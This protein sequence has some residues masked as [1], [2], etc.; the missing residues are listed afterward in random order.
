MSLESGREKAVATSGASRVA[1][2]ILASRVFGFIRDRA[3]AFYLGV[4][5]HADVLR[6]ALR[7]PNVLQNLLGEG[8]LSAAF[9]PFY[10]RMLEEGREREAGRF[11]G[12]VFGLLLATAASLTVIGVFLARPIVA[13]LAPGFLGDAA[14]VEAGLASVD[15]FPLAVQAVRYLFPMAGVL[16][17]SA[18][19]LGVLNSHRRFFLPY[20]APVFWN[21]AI[22]ATLVLAGQGFVAD[23]R[24]WLDRLLLAACIGALIG[25][26]LQFAVQLPLVAR[27]IKGF[28]LSFSLEVGGVREAVR[29]FGPAVAGRGAYQLGAYLD[30]LL[31]SFLAVGAPSAL[32]YAQTLYVL[33]VSLFGL[34]VAAAELPELSRLGE[35]QLV[36]RIAGALRQ[37]SF[38]TIPTVVGYLA[39]GLLVVGALFRTGTFQLAENWLVYL[40]L[41]G[42]ALGLLPT[43]ASRLL[44]NAFYALGDTRTPARIAVRRVVVSAALAL[45][46]MFWLDRFSVS[47]L[48]GGP[49]PGRELFL[50]AVGLAVGSVA[51]AWLEL[52]LLRRALSARLPEVSI[53]WRSGSGFLLMAVACALPAGVLWKFL[54][55]LHVAL[56][57]LVV[58]GS[59]AGVYLWTTHLL[60]VSEARAWLR[61]MG[62]R[63]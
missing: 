4:G 55:H 12:A 18:W 48:F 44:Q 46:L 49:L 28:R 15:R 19:A 20:F 26:F 43:T 42:Y 6:T 3:I 35:H 7:G 11:A 38:L 61:R 1:A 32:A 22:I 37:M 9:I 14:A 31:A 41:A 10:S 50:G 29:A 57:A 13:L 36:G 60:G 59:Y 62:R 39:F 30:L 47:A 8:S 25:G 17:L 56:T 53:P 52:S 45:P 63:G 54:P 40:V 21:S 51:G 33:P 5:P 58:V 24:P 23:S 2:G 27:L 16:V 34:S